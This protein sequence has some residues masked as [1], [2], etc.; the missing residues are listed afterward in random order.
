M[1]QILLIINSIILISEI[2][3][4]QIKK[5]AFLIGGSF[6]ISKEKTKAEDALSPEASQFSLNIRPLA[7]KAIRDNLVVGIVLGYLTQTGKIENAITSE[8]KQRGYGA[9]LFARRYKRISDK[10]SLF[11]HA[12]LFAEI[13]TNETTYDQGDYIKI[14]TLTMSASAYPGLSYSVNKKLQLEIA[15]GSL[16]DFYFYQDK[17]NTKNGASSIKSVKNGIAFSS[18]LEN[19]TAFQFGFRLLLNKQ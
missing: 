3:N 10:F 5:G 17:E 7:G 1:K 19:A 18:T 12:V 6:T 16:I 8:K 2:S 9:G 11:G 14:K 4:A 15:F 13:S